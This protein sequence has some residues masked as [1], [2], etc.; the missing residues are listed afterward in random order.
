MCESPLHL[1][2]YLSVSVH[3]VARDRESRSSGFLRVWLHM[4]GLVWH[5]E[6]FFNF[7]GYHRW[8]K[9]CS[10]LLEFSGMRRGVLSHDWLFRLNSI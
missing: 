5:C 10:Q 7:V 2:L 3:P 8:V 4:R 1:S 9:L 6:Y